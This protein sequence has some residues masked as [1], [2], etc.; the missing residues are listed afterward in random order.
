MPLRASIP[1][2]LLA[3]CAA[4]RATQP[5]KPAPVLEP[6]L[7]SSEQLE[8]RPPKGPTLQACADLDPKTCS[9][10]VQRVCAESRAGDRIDYGDPCIACE[11]PEIVAWWPEA[12]ESLAQRQAEP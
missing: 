12:C 5:P 6:E 4:P 9:G 11:D 10:G 1:L 8:P 7:Y 3:A 2:L